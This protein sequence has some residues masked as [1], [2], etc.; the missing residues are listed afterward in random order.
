MTDIV[1][2][3]SWDDVP[4]DPDGVLLIL[5]TGDLP[6]DPLR[7][8]RRLDALD[9]PVVVSLD[10]AGGAGMLAL[11][12]AG[13]AVAG[14]SLTVDASGVRQLLELGIPRRL[15]HAVGPLAARAL[16]LG[17]Q[18]LITEKL[19]RAG[20][21]EPADRP[22]DAA[23]THAAR[24]AGDPRARLLVRSI[25]AASRSTPTQAAAFDRELLALLD[26]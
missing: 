13:V 9:V 2:V 22:K 8:V 23:R 20:V 18:P 25:R 10:G 14:T 4:G 11:A 17:P 16:L 7:G 3:T 15:V 1:E 21:V 6:G 12:L 24:L 26:A 19:A 5:A